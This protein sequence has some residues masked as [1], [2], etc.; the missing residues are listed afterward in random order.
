MSLVSLV[1]KSSSNPPASEYS[2]EKIGNIETFT[3]QIITPSIGEGEGS[4]KYRFSS[5]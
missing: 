2:W 3:K 4:F 1:I 5:I